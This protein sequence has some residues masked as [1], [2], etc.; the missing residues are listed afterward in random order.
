MLVL[1]LVRKYVAGTGF[2][3]SLIMADIQQESDFNERAYR[4]DRNGG[5]FGLM[6]LDVP[7]ARDRGYGG[8]GLGLYN[9]EL[10]IR[11]GVAQFLWIKSELEKHSAWSIANLLAAYNEGVGNVLRGNPDPDY[12]AKVLGYRAA[13]QQKLLE[14]VS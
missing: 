8:D 13:W 6:Q 14:G 4:A 7:T 12:V 2:M 9:P 3:P 1:P 5:S 11:F 10:N